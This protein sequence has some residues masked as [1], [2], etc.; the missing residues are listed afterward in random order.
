[1]MVNMVARV[2]SLGGP[3]VVQGS[4][5]VVW[6]WIAGEMAGFWCVYN[7]GVRF[8]S[9]VKFGLVIVLGRIRGRLNSGQHRSNRVNRSDL[10]KQLIWVTSGFVPGRLRVRSTCGQTWSNG[11]VN[12]HI[13]F[14]W[15]VNC[16]ASGHAHINRYNLISYAI[17][18]I[19]INKYVFINNNM[20]KTYYI[21][22]IKN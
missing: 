10:V 21:V 4:R 22:Q 7:P 11:S 8:G 13:W 9:R 1:M 14:G 5:R 3:R 20:W 6:C 15:C 16:Y 18:I 2:G 12:G 17:V 19:F